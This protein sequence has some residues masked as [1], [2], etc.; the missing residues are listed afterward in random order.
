MMHHLTLWLSMQL[1]QLFLSMALAMAVFL[2]AGAGIVGLFL[3]SKRGRP[4]LER[5]S[6]RMGID[7]EQ[8]T[9]LSIPRRMQDAIGTGA[10]IG[11][12]ATGDP[13]DAQ[14]GTALRPPN[15]PKH[16][17]A[18]LASQGG[19]EPKAAEAQL[20]AKSTVPPSSMPLLH[21]LRAADR[22]TLHP[23]TFTVIP[24]RCRPPTDESMLP[25]PAPSSVLKGIPMDKEQDQLAAAAP[26]SDIYE[27]VNLTLMGLTPSASA[28]SSPR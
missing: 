20:V 10:E 11:A 7:P 28:S 25:P 15:K 27:G 5:I 3:A 4:H 24:A 22:S 21:A 8:V 9:T 14:L 16:Q 1:A 18:G 17:P 26:V 19:Q 6:E 2:V 23:G 12:K 13:R